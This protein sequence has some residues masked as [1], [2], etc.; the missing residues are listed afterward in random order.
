VLESF[1]NDDTSNAKLESARMALDRSHYQQA[2]AILTTL[3][4]DNPLV[5]QY[6]SNAYAGLA[7]VDSFNLLE[8][9]EDLNKDN[10]VGGIT[11]VGVMH[12]ATENPLPKAAIEAKQ[13]FLT[14]AVDTMAPSVEF[15]FLRSLTPDQRTQLGLLGLNQAIFILSE[16]IMDDMDLIEVILSE[17]RLKELYG[18]RMVRFQPI[19]LEKNNR[20]Q[21]LS[22]A[23]FLIY[24]SVDALAEILETRKS[25]LAESFQEFISAIDSDGDRFITQEELENYINSL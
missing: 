24:E 1:A 3:N 4:P 20:L 15:E 6:L 25:D 5:R 23:I 18:G 8:T 19:T 21:N 12:G 14:S 17:H 16:I 13:T 10:N 7:G 22:R 11:L 2:L 9:I